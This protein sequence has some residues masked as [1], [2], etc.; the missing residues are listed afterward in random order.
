MEWTG[1]YQFQ[2]LTT[3]L[4]QFRKQLIRTSDFPATKST[5]DFHAEE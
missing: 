5:Q 1:R 2:V 3:N 4:G